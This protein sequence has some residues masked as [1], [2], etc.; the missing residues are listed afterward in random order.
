VVFYDHALGKHGILSFGALQSGYAWTT[1][2]GGGYL[3]S[4]H[5][6]ALM[7]SRDDTSPIMIYV[8]L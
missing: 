6:F 2:P 3:R 8:M 1:W 4:E 7:R 5:L